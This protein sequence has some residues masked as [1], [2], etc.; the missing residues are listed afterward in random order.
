MSPD[1]SVDFLIVGAGFS[2]LIAAERLSN[3]GFRCV[4]VDRR[5]HFAGNAYDR[6]DAA[7]VLVHEYGPHYFRTNSKRIVDYLSA[8]TAW[9]DADYRIKS[10]TDGRYW[11]FPVNLNTFEEL[12]GRGATT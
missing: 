11:S 5:S 3:A 2:G 4:I 1:A 9:K 10:Y 6:T 7:G 12:I 8:F